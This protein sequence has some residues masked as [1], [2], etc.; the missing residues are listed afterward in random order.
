MLIAQISDL[1]V[2]PQGKTCYGQV[3]SN[4]MLARAVAAIAA[5]DP[6]PDVV[7][8]SGDLTDCGLEEE[9]AVLDEIL[10]GLSMPVFVVPGNHDRR[11]RLRAAMARRHGYLPADGFLNFAVDGFPVRLIGLDSTIPGETHG[12]LCDER[13]AWLSARLAEGGG[14]PTLLFMHHPPFPTGVRAMDAIGMRDGMAELAAIVRR[15]P[16]IERVVCGHHHRPIQTRWSGTLGVV[17]PSTAH[18]V[19]LDLRD[20]EPTRFVM[21][22]PGLA[23]HL[24]RDGVMA[25]HVQAIG[26]FGG[27][28]DVVTDPDYPGR[29]IA[30]AG[31]LT[32]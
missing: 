14:K 30:A 4:A 6:L 2:R 29:K 32:G 25:S 13:L 28:F 26:D 12:A 5:L 1:H 23:L 21:E 8:A 19:V 31:A 17:A 3:D 10:S 15:H 27:P 18:Q 11:E 16:E 24:W 22:P 7:I 20:G 9:Y